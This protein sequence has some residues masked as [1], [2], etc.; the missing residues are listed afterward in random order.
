[1]D[2]MDSITYSDTSFW[3][4]DFPNNSRNDS[5]LEATEKLG[6][7]GRLKKIIE[8]ILIKLKKAFDWFVGLFKNKPSSSTTTETKTDTKTEVKSD[9]TTAKGDTKQKDTTSQ[10]KTK[11]AIPVKSDVNPYIQVLK[12]LSKKYESTDK[13]ESQYASAMC[14]TLTNIEAG[15]KS[16]MINMQTLLATFASDY[17]KYVTA[18]ASEGNTWVT[19]YKKMFSSSAKISSNDLK[20]FK[21]FNE[22]DIV[23]DTDKI[24]DNIIDT[25]TTFKKKT[26][27][28]IANDPKHSEVNKVVNSYLV[29]LR[30]RFLRDAFEKCN[31][32]Q[33]K[34]DQERV[35]QVY[36]SFN[37]LLSSID[38]NK[39]VDSNAKEA[40]N[41]LSNE[42][43]NSV[44]NTGIVIT[45]FTLV[46]K[47]SAKAFS[48]VIQDY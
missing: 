9:S 36:Q 31:V 44:K 40:Y 8:T 6:F 47:E 22:M 18:F 15:Y 14:T 39:L 28:N 10:P 33:L 46:S 38:Q 30:V 17:N 27:A 11:S 3:L 48:L 19:E 41:K 5:A 35:Q 26:T 34:Q 23:S 45:I 2:I 42:I 20:D 4:F 32:N 25:M 24:K 7:V 43:T 12:S 29:N 21:S 16:A 37:E 1:M 13:S